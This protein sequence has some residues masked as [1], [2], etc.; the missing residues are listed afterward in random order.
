MKKPQ[1]TMHSVIRVVCAE[2][3]APGETAEELALELRRLAGWLG[4]DDVVVADRGDLAAPLAAL[5]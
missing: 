3:S 4:L 5:L 2:V 1:S